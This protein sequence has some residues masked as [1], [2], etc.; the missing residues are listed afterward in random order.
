MEVIDFIP[1]PF[2]L[3]P[4]ENGNKYWLFKKIYFFQ[5]IYYEMN[6]RL[7]PRQSGNTLSCFTPLT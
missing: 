6:R 7:H 5:F 1:T 3:L 4:R 2:Q